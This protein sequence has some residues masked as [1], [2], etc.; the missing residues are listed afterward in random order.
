MAFLSGRP[1]RNPEEKA[2]IDVKL[3]EPVRQEDIFS[4]PSFRKH[5]ESNHH[6]RNP[7]QERE[8]SLEEAAK[9]EV[10]RFDDDSEKE[11]KRERERIMLYGSNDQ[12]GNASLYGSEKAGSEAGLYGGHNNSGG[13]H[14]TCCNLDFMKDGSVQQHQEQASQGYA[15][16]PGAQGGYSNTNTRGSAASLYKR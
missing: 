12:K 15:G 1:Q 5:I 16:A 4:S 6:G 9:E 8:S 7:F 2:G 10:R 14:L 13:D 3:G 11:V